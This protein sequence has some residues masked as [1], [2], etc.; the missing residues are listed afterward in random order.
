VP[1]TIEIMAEARVIDVPRA[2]PADVKLEI[3]MKAVVREA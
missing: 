2:N 1:T 3:V